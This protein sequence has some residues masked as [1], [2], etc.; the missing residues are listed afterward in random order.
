MGEP[1]IDPDDPVLKP[2]HFP[3]RPLQ[4]RK[5]LVVGIANKDSIAYGVAR[6]L[7]AFGA[8]LAVTYLNDKTKAYTWQLAE[9]LDV[10]P[11][12]YL[13][14]DVREEGQLERVFDAL[15]AEWGV[16]HVML[17]AIAYSPRDDLHGRVTDCSLPGFLTTME[18]SVWSLIRMTH[19]AEP[20]M[21]RDG[22]AIF[23]LSYFGG[24]KVVVDYGIM[25][26][27]KAALETAAKYMA[28]ELG[29]QGVRINVIS[30]GPVLTR[31]ASGISRFDELLDKVRSRAPTH[32]L[33]T[34]DQVGVAT[35]L[36][37]CDHLKIVTGEVLY[38]D[39]GYNIMG[40]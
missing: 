40:G 6:A 12:L 16:L 10:P 2:L 14:C 27:A 17:H 29:S 1:L 36:L 26:A 21:R 38:M 11:E 37:A 35:A 15:S 4:G 24:E 25:G 8:D 9:A 20:L 30:P 13:Q 33:V 34:P 5:A 19:L 3:E 22:G 28:A 32:M 7:R 39:G 31:A 23:T 18:I